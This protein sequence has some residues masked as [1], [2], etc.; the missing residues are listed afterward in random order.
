MAAEAVGMGPQRYGRAKAV[1]EAADKDPSLK[2]VVE[3]MD[4]TGNVDRAHR[5]MRAAKNATAS[6]PVHRPPPEPVITIL[7]KHYKELLAENSK[8]HAK[9]RDLTGEL[10]KLNLKINPFAEILDPLG[11]EID[12]VDRLGEHVVKTWFRKVA[13]SYH[14]DR[15]GSTPENTRV[16]QALL[17]AKDMLVKLMKTK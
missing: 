16:F 8:L 10:F 14:P 7:E 2:A 12:G 11:R 6:K 4:R 13:M 9:I 3:E 1:V 17:E 5:K 15:I